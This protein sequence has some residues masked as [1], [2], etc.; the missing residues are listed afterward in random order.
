M[1]LEKIARNIDK[2]FD[3]LPC[4]WQQSAFSGKRCTA[5]FPIPHVKVSSHSSSL[6]QSPSWSPH[7]LWIVQQFQELPLLLQVSWPLQLIAS[8]HLTTKDKK[9]GSFKFCFEFPLNLFK[10]FLTRAT[11]THTKK[12]Q[13]L[14]ASSHATTKGKKMPTID[15]NRKSSLNAHL[16]FVLNFLSICL[17]F[18]WLTHTKKQQFTKTS[19]L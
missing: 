2:I 4:S 19:I 18:L 17:S 3:C 14:V 15:S 10:I 11:D 9:E 13:F 7:L 1:D 5:K 6:S 8:S 16:N 12:E